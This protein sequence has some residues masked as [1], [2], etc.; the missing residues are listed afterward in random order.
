MFS[1]HARDGQTPSRSLPVVSC[2]LIF[3]LAGT[4]DDAVT[5]FSAISALSPAFGAGDRTRVV[6][7]HVGPYVAK[8]VMWRWPEQPPVPSNGDTVPTP[9]KLSGSTVRRK[10]TKLASWGGL[11][12]VWAASRC[13][14]LFLVFTL[15]AYSRLA[16]IRSVEVRR[17]HA[18][19]SVSAGSPAG[20]NGRGREGRSSGGRVHD[21]KGQG[22]VGRRPVGGAGGRGGGRGHGAGCR[23]Q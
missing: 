14:P 2:D 20:Y 15:T 1:I 11:R 4:N 18:A 23:R 10:P 21:A 13:R 12:G 7:A 17:A 3:R 22:F 9:H 16:A 6:L 8:L 19:L 5:S